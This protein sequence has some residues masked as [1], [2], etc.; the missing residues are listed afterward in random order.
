MDTENQEKKKFEYGAF[1]FTAD[2][3][4]RHFYTEADNMREFVGY[5]TKSDPYYS[6]MRVIEYYRDDQVYF[7]QEQ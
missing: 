6:V 3:D 2:G 5:L 4:F 1:Y 7:Q